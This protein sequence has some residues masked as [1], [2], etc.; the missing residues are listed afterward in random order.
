MHSNNDN[1]MHCILTWMEYLAFLT[2]ERGA[3]WTNQD[4]I[5]FAVHEGEAYGVD[6]PVMTRCAPNLHAPQA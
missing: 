4:R 6:D 3:P 1:N 5:V 2:T